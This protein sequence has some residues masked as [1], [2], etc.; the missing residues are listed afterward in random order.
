MNHRK[1]P[2]KQGKHYEKHGKMLEEMGRNIWAIVAYG[3]FLD[4]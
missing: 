1:Y 4:T 2:K 3:D